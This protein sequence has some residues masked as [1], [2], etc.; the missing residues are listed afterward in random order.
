MS[1]EALLVR[2]TPSRF[3]EL[4][5]APEALADEV[6]ALL[7]GS[8]PPAADRGV[9]RGERVVRL[10]EWSATLAAPGNLDADHPLA[11]AVRF[12]PMRTQTVTAPQGLF[13]MNSDEIEKASVKLAERLKKES[14]GDLNRA[15]DLG[16]R[17]VLSRPPAPKE[18]DY[19]LTYVAGDE[20]RLKGLAW[21]LFNLDEFIY[22][23]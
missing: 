7:H 12:G 2:V 9:V 22:V 14:I 1:V 8:D 23:Q 21:L 18:K 19:A 17:L 3:D 16:Y 5:R 15:V 11:R 4:Q 6:E 20:S 10:D 13:L